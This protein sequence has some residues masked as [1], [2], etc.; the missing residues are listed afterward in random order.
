MGTRSI[1]H[2]HEMQG[3]SEEKIVCSFYRH[4][5]GYPSG[6]GDDLAEFLKDKKLVNGIGRFFDKSRDFNSAGTMAVQLMSYIQEKSG[7]EVI[8]TGKSN[9]WEEYTYDIF[10]RNDEF[11]IHI[12]GKPYMVSDFDGVKIEELSED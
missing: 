1:T 3:V 6:H 5:D 9:Y 11:E 8:P 2:I 12:D 10:F 7:C 4:W